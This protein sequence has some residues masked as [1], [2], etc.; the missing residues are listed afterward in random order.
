MPKDNYEEKSSLPFSKTIPLMRNYVKSVRDFKLKDTKQKQGVQNLQEQKVLKI[1]MLSAL[2]LAVF[3]IAFGLAVKSLTV[4][5]DGFISLISV[6]LGAMSLITSR[7]IYKDDDDMFQY[8]YVRFE[9]MVNLFKS[10]V[11]IFVCVYAFINAFSSLLG[12][13]YE[14]HL[15]AATVYSVFAFVFCLVLFVYTSLASKALDSDLI[16]VDNIEWKIDCVLYMG[17]I[18]AFGV[19]YA[20]FM[21]AESLGELG[22][23]AKTVASYIDPFLLCVLSLLLCISPF[24]IAVANFKDLVMLAPPE[25]DDKITQIMEELSQK[26]GFSDYDTHT[27]KSGRFFMVEVN[28]LVQKDFQSP[29]ANLDAIREEIEKALAMPSYRIWLSVSFTA[30]PLWL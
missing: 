29:V 13:G 22:A 9:P 7:Y 14:V 5:F 1:S 2:I 18:I 26:Y 28:I 10:L 27:A 30:N 15:G 8:G 3:G 24:K 17:A 6:G 25:I 11:L 4:V 21:S 23:N 19:V 12:G 16:R 20:L